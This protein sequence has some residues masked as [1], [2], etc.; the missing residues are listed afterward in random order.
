MYRQKKCGTF[1]PEDILICLQVSLFSPA[2][3]K[4]AKLFSDFSLFTTS[5]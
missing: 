1:F 3:M 4:K 2:F 5:S